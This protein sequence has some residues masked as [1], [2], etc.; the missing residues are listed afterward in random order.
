MGGCRWGGWWWVVRGGEAAIPQARDGRR[1]EEWL[2]WAGGL[3]R[4]V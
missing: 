2:W 3:W 4:D 1:A